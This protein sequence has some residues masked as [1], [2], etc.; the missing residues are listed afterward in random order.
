VGAS[1]TVTLI[2]VVGQT[3]EGKSEYVLDGE[4]GHSV[5]LFSD[6]TTDWKIKSEHN[7]RRFVTVTTTS[8]LT[9]IPDI[10]LGDTT[11]G[12]FTTTL[13]TAVGRKG[14]D[15]ILKKLAGS[16]PKWTVVGTG[17][18]TFDGQSDIQ[19]LG[20]AGAEITITSDGSNWIVTGS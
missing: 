14:R 2:P 5:T 16:A 18:Q 11:G 13:P 10:L 19:L 8:T 17:G 4:I 3:I 7:R 6:G 9:E 15:V 12:V 1:N 20:S